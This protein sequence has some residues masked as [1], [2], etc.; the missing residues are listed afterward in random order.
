MLLFMLPH[1]QVC[2]RMMSLLHH[3]V[4]LRV[5]TGRHMLYSMGSNHAGLSW[6]LA[7]IRHLHC[8]ARRSCLIYR[9]TTLHH[10]C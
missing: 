3:L 2:F 9:L 5:V 10:H 1:I 4:A 6:N 8:D 7:M